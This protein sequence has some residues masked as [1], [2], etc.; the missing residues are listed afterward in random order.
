MFHKLVTDYKAIR[1]KHT[2]RK[3]QTGHNNGLRKTSN[4][5]VKSIEGYST[6]HNDDCKDNLVLS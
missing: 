5:I 3:I 4:C 1:P 2:E 6:E